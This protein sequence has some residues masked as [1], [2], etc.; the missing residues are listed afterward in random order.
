MTRHLCSIAL[1]LLFACFIVRFASGGE[2][3]KRLT[4]A[5]IAALPA[6][7]AGTGT[8]GV[9]GIRTTILSGDPNAGGLYTIR[10]TIPPR[11]LINPHHHRDDRV[12][13]VVSGVWY[14]GYGV[15]RDPGALKALT[16]GSFYTEPANAAHFA[17][18]EEQ[19]AV[20]DITGIGPS[21]TIYIDGGDGPATKQ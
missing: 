8:S 18:T 3:S 20:V 5:E 4:P 10:I 11:T 6:L 2:V 14:I 17:G 1:G 13:T 9:T 15:K 7:G 19:P 12:A 21:D 16:A